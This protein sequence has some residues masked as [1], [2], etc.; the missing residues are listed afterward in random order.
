MAVVGIVRQ[1]VVCCGHLVPGTHE[2]GAF[3]ERSEFFAPSYP[4]A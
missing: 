2:G 4:S 1:L 3:L